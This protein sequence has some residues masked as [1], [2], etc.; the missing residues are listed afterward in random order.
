M[1]NAIFIGFRCWIISNL[2]WTPNESVPNKP[3]YRRRLSK[4]FIAWIG[5]LHRVPLETAHIRQYR[6][7][8]F[9]PVD[10][11]C[12]VAVAKEITALDRPTP[13]PFV[14]LTYMYI[15]ST[16]PSV[17]LGLGNMGLWNF[18]GLDLEPTE[19]GEHYVQHHIR[20]V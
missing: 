1:V 15:P 16:H 3:P 5:P 8:L 12:V 20:H 18:G 4:R 13:P 11:C 9:V 17:I 14:F 6:L 19:I 7:S 2:L 10:R